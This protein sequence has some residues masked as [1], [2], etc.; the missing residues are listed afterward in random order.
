MAVR[1]RVTG[2]ALVIGSVLALAMSAYTS[3]QSRAFAECQASVNEAL[4]VAQNARA[5]AA[6]QDRASDREESLATAE[7]IRAVFTARSQDDTRAAY[8]AYATRL[9]EITSQRAETERQRQA[10]PLPAPPSQI[11]R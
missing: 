8:L 5:D 7:L 2:L 1:S 6:E 9:D 11:C 3:Y 4:I 10:N